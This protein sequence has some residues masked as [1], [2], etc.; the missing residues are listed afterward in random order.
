MHG[1]SRLAL[2][3][4]TVIAVALSTTLA[5][6]RARAAPAPAADLV[7]YWSAGGEAPIADR[8]RTTAQ[9]HGAAVVDRSPA[10]EA[11]PEAPGMLAAGIAAYDDLRYDD[12]E[13]A[14]D[15]ALAA[16]DRTGGDGLERDALADL[17]LYRALTHIQRGEAGAWDELVD[18]ARVDPTRIL[19]PARFPP[20]AIEQLARAHAAVAAASRAHLEVQ[21]PEGCTVTVDGAD[22][23][24]GTV[25]V[26]GDHWVR[27][28]CPGRRTWGRR[29]TVDRDPTTIAAT[30]AAI[31][32]PPDDDALIQGRVAG[33]RAVVDV[34]ISD[35]F[36]RL[37][38]RA[39]DGRELGRATV[40]VTG[41]EPELAIA[42]ALA[43]LL[44]GTPTTPAAR[45]W[46]RSRWTWAAAGAALA[47][48]V[49]VPIII[50]D[51]SGPAPVVIRPVG[52][53]PL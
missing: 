4:L 31:A 5:P 18:A 12:A 48:A 6:P 34:R 47:A 19:D 9:A 45:R 3:A 38:R 17:F 46:Y 24:G 35:G 51:D 52:F 33:A 1:P 50:L 22:A 42:D 53:P 37:R 27:A 43:R 23:T 25:I 49:L 36:A 11:A 30:P 21:A 14:F 41:T 40:A 10:V 13:A 8:V 15:Q 20:R 2:Q 16:V 28:V 26:M 7:V 39:I 44:A 32:P 29:I